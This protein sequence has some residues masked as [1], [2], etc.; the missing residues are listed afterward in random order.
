MTTNEGQLVASDWRAIRTADAA[1]RTTSGEGFNPLAALY[2]SRSLSML[3]DSEPNF[4]WEST[5]T[6]APR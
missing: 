3:A 1:L 4:V 5:W 2:L 6:A